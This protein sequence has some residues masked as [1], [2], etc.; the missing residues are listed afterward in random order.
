MK[1]TANII[2]ATGLVGK[3]LVLQLL[4]NSNFEKVRIFVRRKTEIEHPKL[5]QHIVDFK[6]TQRD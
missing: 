4:E 3:Q 1:L 6:K 5:E 2:G